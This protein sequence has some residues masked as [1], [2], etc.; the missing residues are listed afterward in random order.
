MSDH[1]LVVV[2]GVLAGVVGT[3]LGTVVSE[4]RRL[5]TG[6]PVAYARLVADL[7]AELASTRTRL[8]EATR[9]LGAEQ[10]L[11]RELRGVV[12]LLPYNADRSED[13]D[14]GASS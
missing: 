9:Q 13:S 7:H 11:T 3:L 12:A 1:D 14:P 6:A 4:T 10:A 5:V 8:D 2:V